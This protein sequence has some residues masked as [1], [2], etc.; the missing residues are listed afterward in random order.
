MKR[1]R[2]IVLVR[3]P[4]S[5][6][7]ETRGASDIIK[8]MGFVGMVWRGLCP[9]QLCISCSAKKG[10]MRIKQVKRGRSGWKG[11]LYLNGCIAGRMWKTLV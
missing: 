10:D 6:G 11:R 1:R 3:W 5:K 8:I 7:E 9:K 4:K 2:W